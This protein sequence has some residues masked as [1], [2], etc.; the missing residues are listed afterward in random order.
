MLAQ[1]QLQPAWSVAAGTRPYLTTDNTQRGLSYNPTTGHLL[2]VNRAGGV[3]VNVLNST[4]GAD[5][6]FLDVTGIS[7]GT[8]ALNLIGVADDGSIYA[9]NLTTDT[10][11]NNFR[12]Y[13][14]ANESATP[15]LVYS[16]NPGPSAVNRFGDT[17]AVRGSG[18]TTQ[19]LAASR[20][21]TVAS[22]FLTP[23]GGTSFVAYEIATDAAAGDIGLGI[24][25]GAG[26]DA[27]GT[28]SGR[29]LRHL[30]IN[31]ATM[32][33][34]TEGNFGAAEGVPTA[35][36]FIGLEPTLGLLGGV[37]LLAD[38]DKLNLYSI[39]TGSPVLWDTELVQS[40]NANLNGT[41]AIDFGG[42]M[43]FLLESNNGLM[44]Y[45]LIPEPQAHLLLGLGLLIL[46]ARRK[47]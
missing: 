6:G 18:N 38:A 5:L 28:A 25:F 24:D 34:T 32:T 43:M 46:F 4:T 13:R 21:G 12:L 2:L 19:I 1:I 8:F 47:A 27:W 36:A 20:S 22:V 33:A 31:T 35:V 17:L 44:A 42:G 23:D 37:E 30:E 11:A 9:G 39:Q 26:N 29:T 16:G 14:W 41:G 15:T 3:S 7:G 10:S 40:A 45:T